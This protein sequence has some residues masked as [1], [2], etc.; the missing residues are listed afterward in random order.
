MDPEPSTLNPQH[1]QAI[2]DRVAPVYDALNHWLSLGQHRIWKAM[3]VKWSNAGAGDAALDLCC[4][5]GDLVQLLAQRVGS[6]G[7]VVGVD[8][9]SAQLAIAQQ[10]SQGWHAPCALDWV[11]ADSLNLP[12]P[13][14]QFDAATLSY[15]LRN[16]THIPTCLNELHR[17]LKPGATAAILDFHRPSNPHQR[18]FQQWYLA[19]IVVPI[20]QHFNL[21]EEY[22]YIAPSLDKFP[23]GPEQVSLALKAGFTA[24][25]HYPIANDMMGVLVV[26]K[27]F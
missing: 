24:A 19:N 3:A 18:A 12:F 8:F 13:D 27:G 2:F 6:E 22:A 11:E 5:S 7:R 26:R 20:A 15:G 10:R 4:G 25:T 9:S 14:R 17:V 23:I 21:A 1:V 16:V